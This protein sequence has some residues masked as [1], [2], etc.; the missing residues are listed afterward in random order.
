MQD[1]QAIVKAWNDRLYKEL[2]KPAYE[3]QNKQARKARKQAR[4][5]RE[6]LASLHEQ[7]SVNRPFKPKVIRRPAR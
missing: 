7:A 5:R 1:K 2:S 4:Y 3:K 6:L